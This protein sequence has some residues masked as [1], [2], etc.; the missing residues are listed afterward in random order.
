MAMLISVGTQVYVP[1]PGEVLWHERVG[2][3]HVDGNEYVIVT[4]DYGVYVEELSLS[5]PDLDGCRIAGS[6]GVPSW[7][8][9][10]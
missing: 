1:Y 8:H 2:L 10:C 5:N 9:C 7:H 3:A 6:V 4:P